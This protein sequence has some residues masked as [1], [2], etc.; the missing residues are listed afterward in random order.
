MAG[1]PLTIP[2]DDDA[3]NNKGW[4]AP[5]GGGFSG[6]GGGGGGAGPGGG[7][8]GGGG[9]GS[10]GLSRSLYNPTVP[11]GSFRKLAFGD[12]MAPQGSPLDALLGGGHSATPN[13]LGPLLGGKDPGA[14]TGGFDP[15]NPYGPYAGDNR[16]D[17]TGLINRIIGALGNGGNLDP[18]HLPPEILQMLQSL[19]VGNQ[20]E[21]EARARTSLGARGGF[22]DP[23]LAGATIAN[24]GS[25][26]QSD[27]SRAMT[28]AGLGYASHQ[29]DQLMSVLMAAI[30]GTLGQQDTRLQASLTKD[31]GMDWGSLVGQLGGAA[32]GGP[33]GGAIAK[34]IF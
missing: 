21:Y 16:G 32:L 4:Y 29:N 23:A 26:A 24:S 15:K 27:L 2:S 22:D 12:T 18:N 31:P 11:I 19:G 6:P 3:L 33:I 8:G 14:P 34:K 7:S 30:N 13:P 5:G 1:N 17:I 9:G 28:G 10:F 20:G 25:Q